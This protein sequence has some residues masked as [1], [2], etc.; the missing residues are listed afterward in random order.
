MI[1]LRLSLNV[2]SQKELEIVSKN[3]VNDQTPGKIHVTVEES[4]YQLEHFPTEYLRFKQ[5]RKHSLFFEP[6]EFVIGV[7]DT[8][9]SAKYMNISLI[10]TLKVFLELPEFRSVWK[11]SRK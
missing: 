2:Y 4:Q 8:G 10:I 6:E 3:T 1:R 9:S 11:I 7:D 5:Y